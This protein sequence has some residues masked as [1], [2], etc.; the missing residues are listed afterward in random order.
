MSKINKYNENN[1]SQNYQSN[2]YLNRQEKTP[3]T[4]FHVHKFKW[5]SEY[6]PK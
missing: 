2:K 5:K 4:L 3:V 1:I 6:F